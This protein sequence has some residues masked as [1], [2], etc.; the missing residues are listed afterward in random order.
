MDML[1]FSVS[2][3]DCHSVTV[4]FPRKEPEKKGRVISS[5]TDCGSCT[6]KCTKTYLTVM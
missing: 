1:G 5:L 4:T 6:Q 3:I 2:A